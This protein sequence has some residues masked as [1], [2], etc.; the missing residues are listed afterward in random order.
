M[1]EATVR[2]G[3]AHAKNLTDHDTGWYGAR[4]SND[5]V[6]RLET[7]RPFSGE[8]VRPPGRRQGEGILHETHGDAQPDSARQ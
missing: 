3:F 6:V 4:Q 1:S 8:R 5:A 2:Q 7:P